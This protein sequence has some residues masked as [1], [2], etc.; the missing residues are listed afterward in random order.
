[1][2]TRPLAAAL[3]LALAGCSSGPGGGSG[4][5]GA[6]SIFGTPILLALKAGACAA[7]IVVAAPVSAFTMLARPS[8]DLGAVNA[9]FDYNVQIRDYV[10][11][12]IDQNCGPP[13]VVT[14]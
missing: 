1:M 5:F 10:D 3:V 9:D 7:T 13:Y 2:R 4:D 12:G 8:S 6:I 14:R 11:D